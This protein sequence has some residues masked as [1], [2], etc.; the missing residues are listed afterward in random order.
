MLLV[1]YLAT[2]FFAM[3][4]SFSRTYVMFVIMRFL[5]GVAIA[6]ISIISIVLSECRF[7]IS[8]KTLLL[9]MIHWQVLQCTIMSLFFHFYKG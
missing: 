5:T 3:V 1:S 9:L 8:T 6:G 7:R 4:S 2:M